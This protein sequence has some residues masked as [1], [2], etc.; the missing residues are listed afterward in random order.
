[1][2]HVCD[3]RQGKELG[4]ARIGQRVGKEQSTLASLGWAAWSFKQQLILFFLPPPSRLS[5]LPLFSFADTQRRAQLTDTLL[6][7]SSPLLQRRRRDRPSL[8]TPE[9]TTHSHHGQRRVRRKLSSPST[10]S[11]PHD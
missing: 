8:I 3:G 10:V 5:D 11:Q 1:M 4:G 2:A 6:L 9:F 7:P